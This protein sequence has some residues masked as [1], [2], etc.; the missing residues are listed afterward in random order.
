MRAE[1]FEQATEIKRLKRELALVT[2]ER[3]I[4]KKG[5]NYPTLVACSWLVGAIV[6][7]DQPRLAGIAECSLATQTEDQGH[8]TFRPNRDRSK[9]SL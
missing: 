7:D 4:L 8:D 2:E 3:N 1:G 9:L 6:H 5:V